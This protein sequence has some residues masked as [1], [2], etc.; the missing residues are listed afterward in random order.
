MNLV[1][2]VTFHLARGAFE[3]YGRIDVLS[4]DAKYGQPSS[5]DQLHRGDGEIRTQVHFRQSIL[6]PSGPFFF[7]RGNAPK[8]F[9]NTHILTVISQPRDYFF[10]SRTETT[11]FRDA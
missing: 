11:D 3:I 9:L 2:K 4:N 8:K 10:S 1:Y 6:T 7:S 5:I